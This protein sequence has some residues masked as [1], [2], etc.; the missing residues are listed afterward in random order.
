VAS[1]VGVE[2]DVLDLCP[3]RIQRHHPRRLRVPADQEVGEDLV[4]GRVQ[5]AGIG[6]RKV[7]QKPP[8]LDEVARLLGRGV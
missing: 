6:R 3:P 2:C 4:L 5:V 7:V 8:L 1:F